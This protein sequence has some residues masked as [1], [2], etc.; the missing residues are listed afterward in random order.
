MAMKLHLKVYSLLSIDIFRRLEYITHAGLLCRYAACQRS[1]RQAWRASSSSRALLSS[2]TAPHPPPPGVIT[3]MRSPGCIL[4]VFLPPKLIQRSSQPFPLPSFFGI[5]R[6]QKFCPHWASSPPSRP[7][8]RYTLRSERMET[9][10]GIRNSISLM[11]PSP[12]W[13]WPLPPDPFLMLNSRSNTGYRRSKTSASVIRVL[14]MCVCT[15]GVPCHSGP[16]PLPP[17]IVS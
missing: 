14:V 3:M 12:P 11:T 8:G 6:I 13:C 16:A 5:F 7:Y 4:T 1:P 15:P 17:A 2:P 9:C 10:T